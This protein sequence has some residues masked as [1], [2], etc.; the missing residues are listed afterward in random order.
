MVLP[1]VDQGL[2]LDQPCNAIFGESE[3]AQAQLSQQ[4]PRTPCRCGTNF[5]YGGG[6]PQETGFQVLDFVLGNAT[7]GPS[8]AFASGHGGG[9]FSLSVLLLAAVRAIGP[10]G[11]AGPPGLCK[12]GRL[13]RSRNDDIIT[14]NCCG[15]VWSHNYCRGRL[16]SNNYCKG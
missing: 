1:V 2:D 8:R 9:P 14:A 3:F 12:A 15:N 11:S 6:I 7:T 10:C 16:W 5:D 4:S 13:R